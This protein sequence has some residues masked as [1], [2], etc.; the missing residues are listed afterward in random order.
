[1]VRRF[2]VSFHIVK[3]LVSFATVDVDVDAH[4]WVVVYRYFRTGGLHL[5]SV[6]DT[7]LKHLLPKSHWDEGKSWKKHKLHCMRCD[8]GVGIIAKVQSSEKILLKARGVSIQMPA[9]QSPLLSLSGYPSSNLTFS[10]WTELIA[11]L[12]TQPHLKQSL[13]IR[14]VRS[15]FRLFL[16]VEY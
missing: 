10:V 8:N 15:V 13:Q 16:L 4:A 14:R 6:T 11:M 1:M 9:N 5:A 3:T 7:P 2:S 12:E